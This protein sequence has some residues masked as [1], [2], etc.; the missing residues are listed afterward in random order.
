VLVEVEGGSAPAPEP[1]ARHLAHFLPPGAPACWQTLGL[2]VARELIERQ[3]GTLHVRPCGQGSLGGMA[4]EV[5][6]PADEGDGA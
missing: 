5:R 6:L 4:L 1:E 2:A 3:G